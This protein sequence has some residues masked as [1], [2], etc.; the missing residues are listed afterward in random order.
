[1][2]KL[3]ITQKIIIGQDIIYIKKT[4]FLEFENLEYFL[5][6][7]IDIIAKIVDNMINE[8]NTKTTIEVPSG[9]N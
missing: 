8:N 6:L 9:S 1:M 7:I 5:T 2:N 4:S 3:K